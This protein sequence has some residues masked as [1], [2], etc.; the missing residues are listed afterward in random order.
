MYYRP[1]LIYTELHF[2]YYDSIV[3]R[4]GPSYLAVGVRRISDLQPVYLLRVYSLNRI[5]LAAKLGYG[6][7]FLYVLLY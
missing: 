3:V 4:S 1:D 6:H 5:G 2:T 7:E